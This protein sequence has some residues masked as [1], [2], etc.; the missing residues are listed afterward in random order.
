[1]RITLTDPERAE[2][3]GAFDGVAAHL[4]DNPGAVR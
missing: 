4:A 2:I 1:M 3:R